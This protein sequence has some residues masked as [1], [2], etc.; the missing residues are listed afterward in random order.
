MIKKLRYKIG[1]ALN[2]L[3]SWIGWALIELADR[4]GHTQGTEWIEESEL[5]L[6]NRVAGAL[7][8]AGCY[9]YEKFEDYDDL[10][11]WAHKLDCEGD[12]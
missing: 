12:K 6:R 2:S 11:T 9:F 10:S 1:T 5:T 7:Y 4:V 3:S 8:E